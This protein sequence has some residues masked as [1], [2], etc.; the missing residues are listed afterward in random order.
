MPM[1]STQWKILASGC[2]GSC[3]RSSRPQGF[4]QVRRYLHAHE[5]YSPLACADWN[6][7]W[8]AFAS[9]AVQGTPNHNTAWLQF[10]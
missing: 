8:Q 2:C 5:Y 6:F 3:Y 7:D 10:G 1:H 9:S 4:R